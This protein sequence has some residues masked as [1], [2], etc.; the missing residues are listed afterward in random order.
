MRLQKNER[1]SSDKVAYFC[2]TFS[3]WQLI[4]GRQVRLVRSHTTITGAVLGVKKGIK[5]AGRA[6]PACCY[7]SSRAVWKCRNIA[8]SE[9]REC[10]GTTLDTALKMVINTHQF[11]LFLSYSKTASRLAVAPLASISTSLAIKVK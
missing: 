11:S 6:L 1:P 3:G 8:H 9:C 7:L 10:T 4:K 2:K 5:E